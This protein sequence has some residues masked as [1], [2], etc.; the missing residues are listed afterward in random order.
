MVHSIGA[1]KSKNYKVH[2]L[3]W[4]R[5]ELGTDMSCIYRTFSFLEINCHKL[6]QGNKTHNEMGKVIIFSEESDLVE[7]LIHSASFFKC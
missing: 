5:Q 7:Y 4:N 2:M 6:L 1:N 3:K